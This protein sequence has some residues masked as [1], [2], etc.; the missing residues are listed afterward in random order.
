MNITYLFIETD[1]GGV[2]GTS[3]N[4]SV[5]AGTSQLGRQFAARMR[6]RRAVAYLTTMTQTADG[7]LS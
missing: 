7:L 2:F 6:W 3:M 4:H 1:Y 5:R